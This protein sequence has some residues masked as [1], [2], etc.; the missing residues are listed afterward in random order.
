M[1][2]TCYGIGYHKMD[3]IN[4]VI[5]GGQVFDFTE[6]KVDRKRHSQHGDG[7]LLRKIPND[8]KLNQA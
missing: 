2:F 8:Q 6:W 7:I 4:D 5:K 3:F 1:V